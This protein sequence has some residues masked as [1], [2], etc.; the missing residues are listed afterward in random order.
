MLAFIPKRRVRASLLPPSPVPSS[1]LDGAHTNFV[2]PT[3]SPFPPREALPAGRA[4][5]GSPRTFRR[6]SG[7]RGR[8]GGCGLRAPE[9]RRLLRRQG[10]RGRGCCRLARCGSPAPLREA[11]A[12]QRFLARR[13]RGGELQTQVLPARA[14]HSTE[15][16]EPALGVCEPRSAGRGQAREGVGES[17]APVSAVNPGEGEGEWEGGGSCCWLPERSRCHEG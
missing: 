9:W 12:A 8:A 11:E 4:G 17:P 7:S 1:G 5:P 10:P 14:G 13:G 2:P 15:A 6:R 3:C 16:L